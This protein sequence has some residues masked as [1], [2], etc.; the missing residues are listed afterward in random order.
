MQKERGRAAEQG[1]GVTQP[2]VLGQPRGLTKNC[3]GSDTVPG[4]QGNPLVWQFYTYWQ[5]T[6]DSWVRDK[7]SLLLRATVAARSRML[8]PSPNSH[9][10]SDEGPVLPVHRVGCS[11]GEAS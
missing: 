4:Q 6:R 1:G 10:G 8:P 2:V 9:G 7:N 5:K 11:P 3:G